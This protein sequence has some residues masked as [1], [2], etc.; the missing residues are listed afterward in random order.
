MKPKLPM[1]IELIDKEEQKYTVSSESNP[2]K[3]YEVVIG[4]ERSEDSCGC[5]A[6][7]VGSRRPC[8]H[9]VSV[10]EKIDKEKEADKDEV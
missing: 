6:F 4:V 7:R 9:L 8:K 1:N 3:K 2:E 5:V 10:L